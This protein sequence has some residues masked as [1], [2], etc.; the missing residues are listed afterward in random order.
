MTTDIADLA[1]GRGGGRT[2]DRTSVRY[3]EDPSKRRNAVEDLPARPAPGPPDD[4]WNDET[5]DAI[6]TSG[7]Q[8]RRRVPGGANRWAVASVDR[9]GRPDDP[10]AGLVSGP[11]AQG[12]RRASGGAPAS[13]MMTLHDDTSEDSHP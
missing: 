9:P 2:D 8:T 10:V 3:R 5:S 12:P 6:R 4:P 13:P 7:E 11:T 1:L